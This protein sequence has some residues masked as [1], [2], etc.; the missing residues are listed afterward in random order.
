MVILMMEMQVSQMSNLLFQN[1]LKFQSLSHKKNTSTT[2]AAE[3]QATSMMMIMM[4]MMM[5]MMTMM[6]M[7]TMSAGLSREI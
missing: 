1:V 3:A 6:M 5:I 4:T 7:V 2:R